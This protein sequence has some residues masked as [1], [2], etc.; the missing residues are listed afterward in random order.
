MTLPMLANHLQRRPQAQLYHYTSPAG[1]QGIL[2]SRSIWATVAHYLN[3][4]QEFQLALEFARRALFS[5]AQAADSDDLRNYATYLARA[6]ERI[7]EIRVCVFSLSEDDNSLSQWRAYSPAA[8][9]YAIGFQS[10]RLLALLR[11]HGFVLGRCSYE[12]NEQRALID[13]VVAVALAAYSDRPPS[14]GAEA[15]AERQIVPMLFDGLVRVAPFI[16]HSCFAD[17]REWRL[18]SPP[19]SDKDPRLET[20]VSSRILIPH[21]VVTLG[22]HPR[23]FPIGDI[24]VGPTAHSTLARSAIVT[25]VAQ[26]GVPWKAIRD[27]KLPI[28][29]L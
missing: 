5:E 6:V 29:Q 10:E 9:G 21:L 26:A 17:E 20:R 7:E 14:E 16:K 13:E 24:V 27:S 23:D 12:T 4:S 19:I 18:V 2:Q 11:P 25:V 15:F 3:D 8:G 22:D 1:A 28:R